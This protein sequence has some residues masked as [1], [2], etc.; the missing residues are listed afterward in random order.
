MKALRRCDRPLSIFRSAWINL[1]FPLDAW[2]DVWIWETRA[3]KSV[4]HRGDR[5]EDS[6]GGIS[7]CVR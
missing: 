7:G 2:S 4:S 6:S 1:D 5:G 3:L